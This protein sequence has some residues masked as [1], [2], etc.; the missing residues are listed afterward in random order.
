MR[1][2]SE[3]ILNLQ[4]GNWVALVKH[5]DPEDEAQQTVVPK[6]KTFAR[7]QKTDY[8]ISFAERYVNIYDVVHCENLE[9]GQ[10]TRLS[11]P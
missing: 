9:Q 6:I 8:N 11:A 3:G 5:E 2:G 7:D 4:S 1:K 10:N